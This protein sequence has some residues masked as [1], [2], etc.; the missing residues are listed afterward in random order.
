MSIE[1]IYA[2]GSVALVSIISLVGIITLSWNTKILKLCVSFLVALAIGALLGDAF[3]HLIPEA[4]AESKNKDIVPLLVLAGFLLFF[5]I[6]Y[7]GSF[8]LQSI[9]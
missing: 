3:I 2:L 7:N 1:A 9:L 5:I 4:L 8:T 6:C